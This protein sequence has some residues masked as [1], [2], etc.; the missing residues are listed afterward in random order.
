MSTGCHKL[1][2]GDRRER[3]LK[4][5]GIAVSRFILTEPP[6]DQTKLWTWTPKE[7]AA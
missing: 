5:W 1:G 4:G 7:P 2:F 3:E 6:K